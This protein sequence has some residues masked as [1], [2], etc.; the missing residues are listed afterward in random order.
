[1]TLAAN[2][3]G[4]AD[5]DA[6]AAGRVGFE[7]TGGG[8]G[9]F[10]VGGAYGTAPDPTDSYHLRFRQGPSQ[11]TTIDFNTNYVEWTVSAANGG[12]LN[13]V[14]L[15]FDAARGGSNGTRGYEIFAAVDGTPTISDSILDLDNE[16]GTRDSPASRS[17]D[18]SAAQYQGIDSITF[19]YYGL[20]TQGTIEFNNMELYGTVSGVS[21]GP[22]LFDFTYDRADGSSEVRIEGAGSTLYKLVEADDLNFTTPDQD[23][24][25]L[26]GASV[27]TLENGDTQV[28]TDG[29]GNATVQFNLGTS[30]ERT[31][32]RAGE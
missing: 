10:D 12:E 18:L 4:P 24:V 31:F 15:T 7:D 23:P 14:S 20:T 30:K 11:T 1:V 27:G 5:G 2:V 21:A 29:D 22:V 19:R 26:T 6:F 17:I 3:A 25:P 13:L 9:Q 16:S 28:R 8:T 32:I